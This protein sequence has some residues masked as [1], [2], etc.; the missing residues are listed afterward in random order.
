MTRLSLFAALLCAVIL[1]SA[2]AFIPSNNGSSPSTLR[3]SSSLHMTVLTSTSG[4]KVDV[5]EGTPMKAACA[6]LGVKP[7]YSCKRGD[8]G[9]CTVS[10]GGSRVK[11]CVGKVPPMPRLKSLQEKGLLVK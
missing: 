2:Q 11:A 10:V 8:C 5:K 4:K 3:K 7:K 6:K 1:G 9:S